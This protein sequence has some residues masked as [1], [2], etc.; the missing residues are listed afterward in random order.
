MMPAGSNTAIAEVVTVVEHPAFA[1]LYHEQ[2]S[3][4]GLEIEEVEVDDVP[5]TTVT[6]YVDR[7]K[8]NVAALDLEIPR[9][10]AGFLRVPKLELTIED[11]R[12]AFSR[13][14][15]LKL[16]EPRTEEVEYEGRALLTNE[17]VERMKIQLPLLQNPVGAIAFFRDELE[18][19]TGLKGTHPILAP[20]I[21]TFL[22]EV[23]FAE[24]LDL[25]DPRL[26]SRLSAQDVREYIRATFVPLIQKRTTVERNVYPSARQQKSVAGDRSKLRIRKTNPRF[27]RIA[28]CSTWFPVGKVWK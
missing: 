21:E 1:S 3:Q 14:P 18:S 12:K 27:Q 24:K 25:F 10:T 2:L 17:V 20:L 5:T 15:P 8:K 16:T 13:Y 9:L 4:E 11:V 19:M 22:T 26:L 28:P 23:L 6:I 7:E